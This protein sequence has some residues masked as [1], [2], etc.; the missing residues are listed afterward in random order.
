MKKERKT[1][2]ICILGFAG[3][4]VSIPVFV[5]CVGQMVSL[6]LCIIGY[7]DARKWDN[8]GSIL[9]LTGGIISLVLLIAAPITIVYIIKI[10][11]GN[12]PAIDPA[13]A[14]LLLRIAL[15][16]VYRFLF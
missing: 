12:L 4:L 9:A 8:R 14:N 1:N 3:S 15:R 13:N 6:V 7:Y 2:F 5:L 11:S 16:L 10:V